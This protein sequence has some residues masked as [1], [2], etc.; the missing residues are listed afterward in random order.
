MA[1]LDPVPSPADDEH[2]SDKMSGKIG[3]LVAASLPRET[4]SRNGRQVLLTGDCYALRVSEQSRRG[5]RLESA[6]VIWREAASEKMPY[7][8]VQLPD[9]EL[10]G[11]KHVAWFV[12]GTCILARAGQHAFP[13][14]AD[15]MVRRTDRLTGVKTVNATLTRSTKVPKTLGVGTTYPDC[16]VLHE[17][18]A[19]DGEEFLGLVKVMTA[20]KLDEPV[21]VWGNGTKLLLT[22]IPWESATAADPRLSHIQILDETS[23][24]THP[25]RLITHWLHAP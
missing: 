3:E 16:L 2:L 13:P 10:E 9:T 14:L 15:A 6:R 19:D 12:S 17:F 11:V 7:E 24:F 4:I 5:G 18:R 23:D 22:M 8:M 25:R 1:T 20:H 21:S